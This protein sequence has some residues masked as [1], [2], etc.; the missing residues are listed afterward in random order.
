MILV[1]VHDLNGKNS[2]FK[3]WAFA[4]IC[5]KIILVAMFICILGRFDL[6]EGVCEMS[7]ICKYHIVLT[8]LISALLI[9]ILGKLTVLEHTITDNLKKVEALEQ[10][11]TYDSGDVKMIIVEDL[12]SDIWCYFLTEQENPE[13]FAKFIEMFW[14]ENA[15]YINVEKHK[16]LIDDNWAVTFVNSHGE[17]VTFHVYVETIS[18]GGHYDRGVHFT[19]ESWDY[20]VAQ[21]LFAEAHA[22]RMLESE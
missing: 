12:H 14:G 4:Y 21:E 15:D 8:I 19:L 6:S 11:E 18:V 17:M 16:Y 3:S 22:Q 13:Y 7:K 5:N 1:K 9:F 2:T 10:L 20:T